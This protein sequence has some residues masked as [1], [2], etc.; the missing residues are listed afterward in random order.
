VLAA[1]RELARRDL[2]WFARLTDIPG[3]PLSDAIDE[4]RF[5]TFTVD[6]LV[7]HH[8]LLLTRLQELADGEL[9]HDGAPCRNL[10]VIMPPGSAKSTYV[11]VVFVPWFM[12]RKPRQNVILGCYGSD[13][14]R[15]QGRRA[16]QLV[17]SRGYAALFDASLSEESSA[18]DEWALSNGSEFMS[19]G[20]LS[21]ITGNR[22][23]ALIIDD[24]VKGRHEADSE[25]V[26]KRTLEEY[27]D[28]L[29]TR[30]KPGGITILIQTRWHPEDLCGQ[31]LPEGWDGESGFITGRDGESWCVLRIAARC[32]S[33]DDPIGREIGEYLW[34]EY[35]GARHFKPFEA[36]LRTWSALYQGRPS[37]GEGI[38]FDI[39]QVQ[40]A[41]PP[42]AAKMRIIAASDF[43][44][45]NASDG[46][47]AD[48]TV[49]GVGGIDE[50]DVLHL[51]DVWVRQTTTDVWVSQ[52]IAMARSWRPIEWGEPGD[53]IRK[54]VAPHMEREM[55]RLDAY[56]HRVE[57]PNAKDKPTKALVLQARVNK[58]KFSVGPD[59]VFANDVLDQMQKFPVA[60]HDDIVDML[61]LLA[62]VAAKIGPFEGGAATTLER[63]AAHGRGG[64]ASRM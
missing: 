64:W 59:A 39:G 55:S 52:Q 33:A 29:R 5:H 24:P 51:L 49:H 20:I 43:A 62:V 35:L 26:R 34:P 30:L 48:Y 36:V 6:D 61:A 8:E 54:S 44:T 1:R 3:A 58:R 7:A 18:A 25:T 28:S 12:A 22:A 42:P 53:L 21:G 2:K 60:A 23:D 41:P 4:D 10:M 14:A 17:R 27:Q 9:T 38:Y 47:K 31:I 46:G 56:F 40:R 19:G 15:R 37:P 11:D 63:G 16:R 32:D 13:L 45:K 50:H 57:Y